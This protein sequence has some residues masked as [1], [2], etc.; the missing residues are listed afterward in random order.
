MQPPWLVLL[1]LEQGLVPLLELVLVLVLVLQFLMHLNH[2]SH[3]TLI[4]PE[5]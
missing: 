2:Q 3:H 1:G 4:I 5:S